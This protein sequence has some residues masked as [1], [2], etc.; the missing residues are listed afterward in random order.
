M[1]GM[2]V[3]AG[4]WVRIAGRRR[5]AS[6]DGDREDWIRAMSESVVS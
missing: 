6:K 2:G 1:I 3:L 4:W 5:L